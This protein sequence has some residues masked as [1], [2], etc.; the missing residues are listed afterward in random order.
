[1]MD[2]KTLNKLEELKKSMM[3]EENKDSKITKIEINIETK[4]YK[5]RN[6]FE[7][8]IYSKNI[9]SN[10][11]KG[12]AVNNINKNI[13]IKRGEIWMVDLG[14]NGN[15]IQSF[16]HPFLVTSNDLNNLHSPNITGCSG[17]SKMKARLPVHVEIE[18][19]CGGLKVNTVILC[20]TLCPIDRSKFLY[21]M[22]EVDESIMLKVK[23]AIN[24]Q[25]GDIKPKSEFERL[26]KETQT[27]INKTLEYIYSYEKVIGRSR[28]K[29]LIDYLL[30]ERSSL[31]NCLERLCIRHGLNYREY[32]IPYTKE[33]SEAIG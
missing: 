13:Q 31:L 9:H 14:N 18:Q 2:L 3:V 4:D 32:Y 12:V 10:I 24:I 7:N 17:T 33:R 1:M 15:S 30:K 28:S 23:K 21:K 29:E 25:N 5:D 6:I 26:P 19:G 16:R 8:K 11:D 22:G 20:E 27:E